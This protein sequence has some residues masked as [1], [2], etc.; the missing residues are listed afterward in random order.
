MFRLRPTSVSGFP[1]CG[2]I[3]ACL[4][5]RSIPPSSNP[6]CGFPALGFPENS[7]SGHTQG[8]AR[9]RR[10]QGHQPQIRKVLVHRRPFRWSKGPLAPSLEMSYQSEFKKT[11]DPT[12]SLPWITMIKVVSPSCQMSVNLPDHAGN[13]HTASSL[14]VSP[15]SLSRSRARD[16]SDGNRLMDRFFQCL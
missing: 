15:R 4:A 13:R 7:R 10:S 3:S 16:F 1:R 8:V 14:A 11:I 9:L 6:A 12:K 2:S 5:L